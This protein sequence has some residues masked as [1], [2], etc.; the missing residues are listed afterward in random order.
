MP[1][2]AGSTTLDASRDS[3]DLLLPH[4]FSSFLTKVAGWAQISRD[5]PE[6]QQIHPTSVCIQYS[7]RRVLVDKITRDTGQSV[8]WNVTRC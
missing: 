8:Y 3:T 2:T 4:S 5:P 7:S 1:S 6:M